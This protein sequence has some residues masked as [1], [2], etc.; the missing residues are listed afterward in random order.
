MTS[1]S[2]KHRRCLTREEEQERLRK[3]IVEPLLEETWSDRH[4]RVSGLLSIPVALLV[5]VAFEWVYALL[6]LPLF[7]FG[8]IAALGIRD[9]IRE[10][11]RRKQPPP[12]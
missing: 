7:F 9:E 4:P 2:Q 1:D 8:I 3:E 12:W 10:H 6:A 5:W 11:R